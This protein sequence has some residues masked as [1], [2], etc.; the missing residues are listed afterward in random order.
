MGTAR[1]LAVAWLAVLLSTAA[2]GG[3]LEQRS[4]VALAASQPVSFSTDDGLVLE[5][6]VF[7]PDGGPTARGVVLAHMLPADQ[8]SWWPEAIRLSARG[9][10][11]L[12]FNFRGYCPGGEA[13]CSGGERAPDAAPIDLASAVTHLRSLGVSRVGMIGASMGGTAGLVVAASDP[14]IAA[15]ITLSAPASVG[16]LSAGPEVLAGVEAASLFIAGT[17]DGSA[18]TAAQDFYN[19]AGQP[20]RLEIVASDDHGTEM[21]AGSAGGRIRDL[22]DLWLG[23]YL[24]SSPA[25]E[26]VS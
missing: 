24:S 9:Y 23:S 22:I 20:K 14:K 5:G 17:G 4:S 2:C 8:T 19:Q 1:R 7:A 21:L 25:P 26:A 13:G 11:V 12:T 18:A 10:T 6:R 15:M 16:G 3:A